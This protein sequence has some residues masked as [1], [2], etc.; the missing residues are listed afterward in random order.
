MVESL[1]AAVVEG[2]GKQAA[3]EGATV[4]GKTGTAQRYDANAK[5]KDKYPDGHFVVSFA[6]F[7]PV[8]KPRLACV[9]VIDDPK[10]SDHGQLYGGKLAAPVFSKVVGRA[11][12]LM[13]IAPDRQNNISLLQDSQGGAQQ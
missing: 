9:I 2:T 7:A 5:G 12:Q 13:A 3:V 11:F 8:E 6:G 10:S 4:A 1:A